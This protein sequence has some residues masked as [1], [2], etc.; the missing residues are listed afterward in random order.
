MT[1]TDL[2]KPSINLQQLLIDLD[3]LRIE[4]L[5]LQPHSLVNYDQ[6]VREIYAIQLATLLL[7][8]DQISE[9]QTR[10]FSIL[11]EAMQLGGTSAKFLQ[12]AQ[13]TNQASLRE[14]LN[15]LEEHQLQSSFIVDGLVLCRL[16]NPLTPELSQ[17]FSEF[18]TL[19][20]VQQ[21]DLEIYAHLATK[22]LGLH[23]HKELPANFDYAAY[24]ID[25]WD[26]FFYRTLTN[27]LLKQPLSNG[28]WLINREVILENFQDNNIRNAKFKFVNKG[29]I[30]L[31]LTT[32]TNI[33][34]VFEN[35]FFYNPEI[36]MTGYGS[37]YR[38]SLMLEQ[39]KI[40]GDYSATNKITAFKLNNAHL[41][42][43]NS[44]V[45]VRNAR[46][47]NSEKNDNETSIRI[48]ESSFIN[49]GNRELVGGI[50][51][52][53]DSVRLLIKNCHFENC[54]A[55]YGGVFYGRYYNRYSNIKNSSFINCFSNNFNIEL[56]KKDQKA[57]AQ[58]GG[59]IFSFDGL[60]AL[61]NCYYKNTSLFSKTGPDIP[62][63]KNT[64]N[65][66]FLFFG[67]YSPSCD[68]EIQNIKDNSVIEQ[69]VFSGKFIFAENVEVKF[70]ED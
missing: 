40:K 44:F 68:S 1:L 31:K 45:E 57:F 49:C 51:K 8:N 10:L 7:S 43:H 3:A 20:Q 36:V 38:A 16:E 21:D 41:N 70:I 67:Y 34:Y 14:F 24:K 63:V 33:N 12:Q 26:E 55:S 27:E 46:L 30:Q 5:P 39:C 37:S 48:T 61:N 32:S 13:L 59:A 6:Y 50:L 52:T 58:S 4:R 23:N 28:R 9:S 18:A 60:S 69:E 11:L 56:A 22:V 42:I 53:N 2:S 35:C 66:S 65:D 25:V 29:R 19:M 64:Y 15:I 54:V 17:V 62:V 47:I